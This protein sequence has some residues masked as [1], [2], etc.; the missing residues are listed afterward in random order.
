MAVY[1]NFTDEKLMELRE[2]SVRRLAHENTRV[3]AQ[4]AIDRI[5]QIMSQRKKNAAKPQ[6]PAPAA[7]ATSPAPVT[8]PAA[9]AAP[10]APQ[11]VNQNPA[12]AAATPNPAPAQPTPESPQQ[13]TGA[14]DPVTI[15]MEITND[16][17]RIVVVIQGKPYK[18]GDVMSRI[19]SYLTNLSNS[20]TA[21]NG[22]WG[23]FVQGRSFA[24][25]CTWL[26]ALGAFPLKSGEPFPT[27]SDIGPDYF[28]SEI[29]KKI[30]ALAKECQGVITHNFIHQANGIANGHNNNSN[31][32]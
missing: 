22:D 6:P 1:L 2:E 18:K 29:R 30:Y 32:E 15:P 20:A 8:R 19:T 17:N 28:R 31:H 12:T 7:R 10:S 5:D 23:A 11:P 3:Q 26:L 27:I 4:M 24:S 13:T 9:A 25:L 16:D 14:A 21:Q